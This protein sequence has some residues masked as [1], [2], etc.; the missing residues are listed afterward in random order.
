MPEYLYA[1]PHGHTMSRILPVRLHR[2]FIDCETCG[3]LAL[4][5]ITAPLMLKVAQDVCYDSPIDGAPI[6]SW[7]ARQEDLKRSGCTPYDPMQKDDATRRVKEQDAALD[8]SIEVYAEQVTEKMSTAQRG[9][10][11]SELTEQGLTTEYTRS[12]VTT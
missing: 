10:I 8:R 7:A 2:P 5:V 1:C 11:Y 3:V 12:T 6:T 4:Q 9:K